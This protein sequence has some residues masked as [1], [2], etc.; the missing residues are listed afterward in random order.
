MSIGQWFWI[1][2]VICF[3][4]DSFIGPRPFNFVVFGKSLVWFILV[5]FLGWH[6]FGPVAHN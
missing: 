1:I 6:C 5:G 2:F 4:F 3:L